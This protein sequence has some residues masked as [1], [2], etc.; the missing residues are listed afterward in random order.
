MTSLA[1]AY[2]EVRGRTNRR[3]YLGAALFA[4]GALA[5]VVGIVFA[6]TDVL[7]SVGIGTYGSRKLAGLLAGLGVP[8]VFVGIFSVLPARRQERA[9]AAVGA[10]VAVFGVALFWHAYP[11]RWYGATPDHLTLPVVAIYFLGTLVTFWALFTAVVNF[12]TR[13]KPGG[14][15]RIER[16]TEG[17][18]RV[19]R[20]PAGATEAEA[21]A[22]QSQ[23]AG[24]ARGSVGVVG[25]IDD[26]DPG[27]ATSDGG[28]DAEVLSEPEPSDTTRASSPTDRY[29][30][31][32][33]YF[34]YRRGGGEMK[35]HCGY[36]DHFMED[37]DPCEAWAPN[38]E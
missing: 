29:C 17:K 20:V 16:T 23:P 31:T 13:N 6:T 24:S 28:T 12:R 36:H 27:M 4:T 19:V 1:K 37:M 2:A 7:A 11:A 9:I 3:F 26:G 34:D 10:S 25:S 18:T 30:G 15:I 35:P 21:A 38:A 33:R 8:S 5:V 14:T 32:C 22:G